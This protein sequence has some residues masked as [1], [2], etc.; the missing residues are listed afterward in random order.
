MCVTVSGSAEDHI[1]QVNLKQPLLRP[2]QVIVLFF[3]EIHH[4]GLKLLLMAI[5]HALILMHIHKFRPP[6]RR[7]LVK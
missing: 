3:V 4:L 6:I 2:Q 5:V 7:G 1:D